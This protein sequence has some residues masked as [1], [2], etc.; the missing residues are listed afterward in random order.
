MFRV[1]RAIGGESGSSKHVRVTGNVIIREDGLSN[2][3]SEFAYIYMYINSFSKCLHSFSI[4][5]K[6]SL[7][8]FCVRAKIAYRY[9]S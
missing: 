2:L 9:L 7:L 8:F 6:S 3:P 4:P 1:V 5:V